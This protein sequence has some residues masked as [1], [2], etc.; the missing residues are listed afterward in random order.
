[1]FLRYRSCSLSPL[2]F[3]SNVP[4]LCTYHSPVHRSTYPLGTSEFAS[5]LRSFSLSIPLFRKQ[6]NS[7][8]QKNKGNRRPAIKVGDVIENTD[9]LG[10]E[11]DSNQVV[12][13]EKNASNKSYNEWRIQDPSGERLYTR[14]IYIPPQ[15]TLLL[16][17]SICKLITIL[18][19]NTIYSED[20]SRKT[21]D[22]G[23]RG[24]IFFFFSLFLLFFSI[25]CCIR[26][27]DE[28]IAVIGWLMFVLIGD[29]TYVG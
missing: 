8:R 7:K 4:K 12:V 13:E 11:E 20:S 5:S 14:N 28:I 25:C 10:D 15:Q 16:E 1:M 19:L 9:E 2:S 23:T 26:P 17:L 27:I 21:M 6:S 24:E 3:H 18:Y 22:K 29:N